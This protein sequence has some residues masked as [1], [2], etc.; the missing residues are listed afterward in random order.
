MLCNSLEGLGPFLAAPTTPH[1]QRPQALTPMRFGLFPFRS[2]LLRESR[3]LSSPPATEMVH[4]AGFPPDGLCIHPPVTLHDERRVTPFGNP[5]IKGC[6]HLPGALS[7]LATP[8]IGPQ[9]LGIH[10][11]PLVA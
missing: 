9:C 2:P 7:L 5:R 10:R 3:L 11:A 4:F 6:L 1:G 8:F